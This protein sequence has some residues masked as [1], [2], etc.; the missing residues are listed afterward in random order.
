LRSVYR[1]MTGPRRGFH[2]P[3]AQDATGEGALHS[4]GT[5]GALSKPATI[6]GLPPAHPSAASLHHAT[7]SITA[8]LRLTSHQRGFMQFARPAFPSPVATGWIRSALGFPELRTPP[9]RAT[10][11]G[12]GTDHLEHGSEISDYGISRTSNLADLL[13]ACDLASLVNPA[14]SGV[15]QSGVSPTAR[16]D[17]SS[18]RV[19]SG[20]SV[21]GSALPIHRVGV[22]GRISACAS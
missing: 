14:V 13:D 5:G 4:P 15:T 1:P 17:R 3:H 9:L 2:V 7:T 18:D 11:V 6:T 22:D 19:G 10:H 8:R 16:G 20:T 21:P 12:E